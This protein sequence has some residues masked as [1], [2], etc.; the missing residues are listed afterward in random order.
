MADFYTK[1]YHENRDGRGTGTFYYKF[2]FKSGGNW[3]KIY[4]KKL[5]IIQKIAGRIGYY[6][7]KII[8]NSHWE[9]KNKK[10]G[11]MIV[12]FQKKEYI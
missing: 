3:Q 8:F 4:F 6:F 1:N 5:N 9:A 12:E 10:S 7:D 11:I 2:L